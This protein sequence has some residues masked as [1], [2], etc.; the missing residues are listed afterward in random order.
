MWQLLAKKGNSNTRERLEL[1]DALLKILPAAKI[2]ALLADREFIG[3]AWFKGL[4][5]RKLSFVM[6]LKNNTLIGYK[7]SHKPASQRYKHLSQGEHYVCPKQV[8]VYGL[9]LHLAVTKAK[10]GELVLLA[11]T[12]KPERALLACARSWDIECLFSALKTRGFNLEDTRLT[13]TTR[14]DSLI[15]MLAVAFA[16]AHLLGEWVYQ[17]RPLKAKTHGYLPLSFFK[18]GLSYLRTAILAPAH[19][20]AKISLDSCL[21]LL[22]P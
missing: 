10:E 22:S 21:K 19:Q 18:R 20:P 6:R 9:R 8:N 1:L 17:Q 5:K 2:E 16:W 4:K 3:K 7:G 11:C 13:Q 12:D 15:I 14:L